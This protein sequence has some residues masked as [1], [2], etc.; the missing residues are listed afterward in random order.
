[1][2]QDEAQFYDDVNLNLVATS[3]VSM[4]HYELV[5]YT[6]NFHIRL[7]D[8]LPSV[9]GSRQQLGQILINL[10]MNACQSLPDKSR[11]VWLETSYDPIQGDVK[12]SVRDEGEGI[13]DELREK[14]LQPFFTTKIESGGTGLGLSISHSIIKDHDGELDF[15]SQKDVG[16]TFTVTL[17]V[18]N[19][20]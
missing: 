1:V 9:R 5:K 8:D 7:A 17:P 3:A 2:R 15:V 6:D 14:I 20:E 10:L 19:P 11:S 13:P 4:L 12:L 18:S 16:T